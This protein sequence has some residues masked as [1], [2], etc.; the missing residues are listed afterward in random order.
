LISTLILLTA[1]CTVN[2][3][4]SLEQLAPANEEAVQLEVP[5]FAQTAFQ[6]GPAALAG[7]LNHS[8]ADTHPDMLSQQV[9]LPEREGSLQVELL[10]A[11]RRE[12]RIAYVLDPQPGHLLTELAWKRPVLVLQNLRTPGFP[13]WHYAVLTGFDT[14]ANEF[15]LNSGTEEHLRLDARKFLRTWDWADRWAMIVLQP[16]EMPSM[17]DAD[18]YL[19]AVANFEATAGSDAAT[20]AWNAAR[21]IW[22]DD[23]RPYLALG[24]AAYQKADL[25][26]AA[27]YYRRG[28]RL[29]PLEPSLIN[30]LASVL[31]ESGCPHEGI[32]LLTP[33]LESL[34]PT[35]PWHQV[36]RNTL[37]ELSR[38]AEDP[39]ASC[40]EIAG[41]GR[42]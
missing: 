9:Y 24:N 8:G 17:P 32:T 37:D 40:R 29:D 12:G 31:G 11:S 2:P 5:F 7:V 25:A 6:C 19:T 4:I 35:N 28:L 33:A 36:L 27:G 39:T 30:N 41:V 14:E 42:G 10:A 13:A 3:P 18:K 26:D 38:A 20:P 1:G 23:G 22:P 15:I 16:G 21:N 34:E